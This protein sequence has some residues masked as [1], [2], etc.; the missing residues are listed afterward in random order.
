MALH[1]YALPDLTAKERERVWYSL[2]GK[3]RRAQLAAVLEL[4]EAAIEALVASVRQ[5][6]TQLSKRR[7]RHERRGNEERDDRTVDR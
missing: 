3:R 1:G 2:A 7:S 6:R 4:D 5:E